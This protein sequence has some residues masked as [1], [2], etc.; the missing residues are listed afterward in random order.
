MVPNISKEKMLKLVLLYLVEK[1]DVESLK[2]LFPPANPHFGQKL[3]VFE[4]TNDSVRD[5]SS[6]DSIMEY[7]KDNDV[8]LLRACSKNN[9]EL[10]RILLLAGYR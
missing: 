2:L 5:D 10:V 1:D 3:P 9:F 7:P 6:T 8:V 4:D